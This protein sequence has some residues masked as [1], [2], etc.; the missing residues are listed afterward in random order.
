M[1]RNFPVKLF[2]FTQNYSSV[3][4]ILPM[5]F[6][7]IPRKVSANFV[8]TFLC[9]NFYEFLQWMFVVLSGV[10]RKLTLVYIQE[11]SWNIPQEKRTLRELFEE[12]HRKTSHGFNLESLMSSPANVSC[13]FPW[14]P[15]RIWTKLA[16]RNFWRFLF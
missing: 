1:F 10:N 3:S 13:I 14:I 6:T 15:W 2:F 12:F 7:K 9:S 8:H 16:P 11:I 5:I 4:E